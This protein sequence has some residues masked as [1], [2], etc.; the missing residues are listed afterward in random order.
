MH[1]TQIHAEKI[2]TTQ[3][4]IDNTFLYADLSYKIIGCFYE[5]RNQYGPGQK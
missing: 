3:I 1:N 4:N 5:I 2:K